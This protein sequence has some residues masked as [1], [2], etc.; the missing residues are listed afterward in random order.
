MVDVLQA[1]QRETAESKVKFFDSKRGQVPLPTPLTAFGMGLIAT[2]PLPHGVFLIVATKGIA[3][4]LRHMVEINTIYQGDVQEKPA[5]PKPEDSV[6]LSTLQELIRSP[7]KE[8]A[9]SASI[10]L[11]HRF[12]AS[13]DDTASWIGDFFS[14][15]PAIRR[16]AQ[17]LDDMFDALQ[18]K[19]SVPPIRHAF[20]KLISLSVDSDSMAAR[21]I[22]AAYA[23]A[24]ARAKANDT[25]PM[26]CL[27]SLSLRMYDLREN[28]VIICPGMKAAQVIP[29]T[30]AMKSMQVLMKTSSARRSRSSGLNS[31]HLEALHALHA[32]GAMNEVDDNHDADFDLVEELDADAD[33]SSSDEDSVSPL[34]ADSHDLLRRFGLD[35]PHR[36]PRFHEESPEEA[37]VRRRRREAMVFHEGVGTVGREDI[38]TT[39][40]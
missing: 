7:N 3:R 9:T 14:P 40:R 27:E 18:I 8:I 31:V 10:L 5:M 4:G 15:S 29:W 2:I 22:R 36:R 13:T 37:E 32:A 24:Q 28:W 33:E 17:R 35:S 19:D 30:A 25:Y 39:N 38:Y 6:A 16:S 21:T 26:H 34:D 11:F 1:A 23:H 12:L 20:A